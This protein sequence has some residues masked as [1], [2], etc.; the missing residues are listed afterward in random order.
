MI[1]EKELGNGNI[2]NI[3]S[4]AYYYKLLFVLFCEVSFLLLFSLFFYINGSETGS[5]LAQRIVESR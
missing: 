5:V 4:S 1:T 3:Y 2:Y